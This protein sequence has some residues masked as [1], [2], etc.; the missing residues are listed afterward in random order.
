MLFKLLI[1][2]LVAVNITSFCQMGADKARAKSGK[3]RI[4]E[5]VL[6]LTAAIGGSVGANVGM[7]AFRHKTKLPSFVIGMPLILLAH[8]ILTLVIIYIVY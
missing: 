7:A 5:R 4:R 3:R 8:I 6:C 1:A 2:Y